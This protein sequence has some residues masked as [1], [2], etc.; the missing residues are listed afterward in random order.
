MN[1]KDDH[2]I[3]DAKRLIREYVKL[4]DM[5][6][7]KWLGYFLNH[8]HEYDYDYSRDLSELFPKNLTKRPASSKRL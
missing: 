2:P 8:T 5:D 4:A 7:F 6:V 3:W 1:T